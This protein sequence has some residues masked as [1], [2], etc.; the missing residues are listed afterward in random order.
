MSPEI[1]MHLVRH[2]ESLWNVEGR[3]QGHA[4]SGLTQ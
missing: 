4:D 2:A 3:Y 1:T